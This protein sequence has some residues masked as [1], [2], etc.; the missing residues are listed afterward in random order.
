MKPLRYLLGILLISLIS[1]LATAY[2]LPQLGKPGYDGLTL[3]QEAELGI[4]FM[5]SIRRYMPLVQDPL[6]LQYVQQLGYR[7][8]KHSSMPANSFRFF[9]VKDSSINAFAAPGGYIGI[10]SGLINAAHSEGELAS[11]M[12]HEI[13]HVTQRH[14]ARSI[15]SMKKLQLV[16]IAAMLAAAALG[17][18]SPQAAQGLAAAGVAG[19]HQSLLT[20]TREH[21]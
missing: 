1:Q 16:N 17:G 7:L 2:E 8:A 3:V 14:I 10:N 18:S 19:S 21:E 4:Q 9:V 5:N 6:V 12:A 11:V 20:H 15:A 13:P